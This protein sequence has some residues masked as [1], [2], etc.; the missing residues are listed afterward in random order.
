MA[1]TEELTRINTPPSKVLVGVLAI[2]RDQ[3]HVE[4]VFRGMGHFSRFC[5]WDLLV[6][7]REQDTLVREK[8][9]RTRARILTVE[10]YRIKK[11]HNLGWIAYK[12]NLVLRNGRAGAYEAVIF[13]DGDVSFGE[14]VV[15]DMFR[16]SEYADI[17]VVPYRIR[18]SGKY[19]VGLIEDEKA[20]FVDATELMKESS[21]PRI[22]G[23]SMGCTLIH[24]S[25][26]D[27]PFEPMQLKEVAGEDIGFFYRIYRERPELVVR[28][29]SW[30]FVAKH[31]L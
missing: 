29:T 6:V 11:R 13:I 7:A 15:T 19:T 20:R 5:D 31:L 2:D 8:W 30:P 28:T 4:T 23:G 9:S 1:T 16:C 14:G 12:R 24:A 18:W 27:V 25:A 21:Y 22:Q 10:D 17:V 3:E 26:F